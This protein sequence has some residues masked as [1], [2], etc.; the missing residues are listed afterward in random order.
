MKPL[1][2][3]ELWELIEPLLPVK[4]RRFR[5]PGR[6]PVDNQRCLIGI[7]FVLRTGISW[8]FLPQEMR[9]GCGMT[10]WRRLRDWQAAGVWAMIHVLLL[11]RLRGADRIDWSRALVDSGSVR[12]VL[13]G[14]KTGPTPVDRR[15]KGTQHPLLVS[16]NGVPLSWTITGANR[17]DI[18]QLLTLVDRIPSVAGK[19]GRPRR[20]PEKVQ[21][22]R[23]YN[24]EPHRQCL[25]RRG[26]EPVLARRYTEHGS[27]LGGRWFIERTLAWIYQHRRLR[28]RYG[29]RADIHEAFL[30]VGCITICWHYLKSSFC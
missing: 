25:R 14:Q 10:C 2:D 21:G 22:D 15:K 7:L 13:G 20:R 16:G 24:S 4:E 19:V 27:G 29:R 26:I 23:A 1:L 30:S 3:D 5:Y 9:C 28:T 11:A 18:T 6:K 17:H 12:A 8:E